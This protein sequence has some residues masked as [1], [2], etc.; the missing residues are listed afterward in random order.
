MQIADDF[1]LIQIAGDGENQGKENFPI[2]QLQ[3]WLCGV[4]C[5]RP[6]LFFPSCTK[7]IPS[8]SKSYQIINLV[9]PDRGT[10]WL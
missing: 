8:C 4:S 6:W 1:S 5:R 9:F 2:M 10:R 3:K 7:L